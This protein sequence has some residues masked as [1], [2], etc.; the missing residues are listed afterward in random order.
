M[1]KAW[2]HALCPKAL[3][4][5]PKSGTF[6]MRH[7]LRMEWPVKEGLGARFVHE[8]RGFWR[9]DTAQFSPG[10]HHIRGHLTYS[11]LAR[12]IVGDRLIVFLYRDP[13]DTLVSW[14]HYVE[15]GVNLSLVKFGSVDLRE[16][17]DKLA[18]LIA[19]LPPLFMAYLDWLDHDVI[20]IRFEGLINSPEE[21]LAPLA[22]A[23]PEP[24]EY[25]VAR[26]RMRASPTFRKGKTGEWQK[27]FKPH[28]LRAFE[29]A[30]GDVMA[31]AG[32]Q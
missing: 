24:L 5:I 19:Y 27:E 31:K 9:K 7:I 2:Y 18:V 3:I 26:S 6:L 28:H 17:K 23:I 8:T 12:K 29:T 21:E 25:L 15:T 4:T 32:Y 22:D 14:A 13:R 30:W 10:D 16:A 1:N 11:G 20:P